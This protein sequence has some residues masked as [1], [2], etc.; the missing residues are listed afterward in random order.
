L[1]RDAIQNL[2]ALATAARALSLTLYEGLP[3]QAFDTEQYQNELATEK[4]V[5]LHVY[6]FYGR[7]LAVSESD[8][9]ELRRLSAS[10]EA[11]CS[12]SDGKPRGGYR[13]DL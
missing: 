12:L 7:A 5:V 11:Y 6:P 10:A 1:S 2:A 8:R 3:H 9:E 13:P 4:T